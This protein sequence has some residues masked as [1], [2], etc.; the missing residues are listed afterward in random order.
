MN[1]NDYINKSSSLHENTDLN[2]ANDKPSFVRVGK[3][4]S[5]EEFEGA[6]AIWCLLNGE[7][8]YSKPLAIKVYN[9]RIDFVW[10]DR[11]EDSYCINDF[12][13]KY[14]ASSSPKELDIPTLAQAKRML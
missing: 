11:D 10:Y 5:L 12:T 6:L 2:E 8:G 4:V 3:S 7:T 1:F 13:A 14:G 9:N